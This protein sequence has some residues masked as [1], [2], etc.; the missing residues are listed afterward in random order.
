MLDLVLAVS[1]CSRTAILVRP[2][3]FVLRC[4]AAQGP[5]GF[6]R[7]GQV[8]DCSLPTRLQPWVAPQRQAQSVWFYDDFR[9][10]D[11]FAPVSSLVRFAWPGPN[12]AFAAP[13]LLRS[14]IPLTT[15]PLEFGLPGN[16]TPGTFRPWPFSSLRRFTPP[17]GSPV[18]FHTDTTYGI[19]RTFAMFYLLCSP[20][21]SIQRTGLSGAQK[22]DTSTT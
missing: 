1:T 21:G 5:W 22:P 8:N 12:A 6:P 9:E 14:S 18:L 16:T 11:R 19:Q 7:A 2:S 4:A 13:R 10:F 17:D 20:C 15:S 3:P